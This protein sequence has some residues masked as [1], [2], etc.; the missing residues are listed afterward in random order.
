MLQTIEVLSKAI[1]CLSCDKAPG[2]DGIPPDRGPEER[3]TCTSCYSHFTTYFACAGN[4][5]KIVTLYKQ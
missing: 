4:R 3:E 2:Y 5:D 1:D